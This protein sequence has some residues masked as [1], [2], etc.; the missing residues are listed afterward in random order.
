[1]TMSARRIQNM[2]KLMITKLEK[3]VVAALTSDEHHLGNLREELEERRAVAEI[4][5]RATKDKILSATPVSTSVRDHLLDLDTEI[6]YLKSV[7]DQ[8][9]DQ[10]VLMRAE[11]HSS[12]TRS[13]Q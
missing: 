2:E 3:R 7:L 10:L 9:D 1:M 11:E 6:E 4:E 12:F 13:L 5:R 8:I